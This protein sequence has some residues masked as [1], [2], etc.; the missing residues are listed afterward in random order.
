MRTFLNLLR[1]SLLISKTAVNN[2]YVFKI[3]VVMVRISLLNGQQC[4]AHS[5]K[6][7]KF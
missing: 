2:S 6:L 7:D 5:L 3:V 4:L 1:L